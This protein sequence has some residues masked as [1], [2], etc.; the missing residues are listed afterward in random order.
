MAFASGYGLE[1][2]LNKVPRKEVMRSDFVLFSESNSRFL[3]E[4]AESDKEDFETLM[5]G[6]NCELIGKVTKEPKLFIVGLN[7][8]S[9]IDASLESLRRSWKKTLNQEETPQ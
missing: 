1:I 5:K 3:I 8:K 6:K 9:A 2:D 4:V 7:G